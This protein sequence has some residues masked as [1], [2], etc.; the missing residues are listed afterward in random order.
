MVDNP[1]LF[2]PGIRIACAWGGGQN[3]YTTSCAVVSA[4]TD[5]ALS[6]ELSS[7][8]GIVVSPWTSGSVGGVQISMSSGTTPFS[9]TIILNAAT[10]GGSDFGPGSDIFEIPVV[11]MP[12]DFYSVNAVVYNYMD[13]PIN[14]I[15]LLNSSGF[16]GLDDVGYA[17]RPGVYKTNINTAAVVKTRQFEVGDLIVICENPVVYDYRQYRFAHVKTL[18]SAIVGSLCINR[19]FS[20]SSESAGELIWRMSPKESS[21]YNYIV[22]STYDDGWRFC[23]EIYGSTYVIDK[24]HTEYFGTATLIAPPHNR[25]DSGAVP[26]GDQAAYVPGLGIFST[27]GY[28]I[29]SSGETTTIYDRE[30]VYTPQWSGWN[31]QSEYKNTDRLLLYQN[32]DGYWVTASNFGEN[33]TL[34]STSVVINAPGAAFPFLPATSSGEIVADISGAGFTMSLPPE[35]G[36][37]IVNAGGIAGGGAEGW[38]PL[39]RCENIYNN[40]MN[41]SVYVV[42]SSFYDSSNCILDEFIND[43]KSVWHSSRSDDNMPPA[44]WE[45]NTV[46]SSTLSTYSSQCISSSSNIER[47]ISFSGGC[48]INVQNRDSTF[49]E[50]THIYGLDKMSG[51][52]VNVSK[53]PCKI[54]NIES[55]Y[56]LTSDYDHNWSDQNTAQGNIGGTQH[57]GS[58]QLNEI[59]NP[60]RCSLSITTRWSQHFIIFCCDACCGVQVGLV[61]ESLKQHRATPVYNRLQCQL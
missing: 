18:Q 10:T 30:C 9:T 17:F 34:V 20:P 21:A 4:T 22:S 25:W 56:L 12:N 38:Y 16:N 52:F 6:C 55:K 40:Y 46:N 7:D 29:N 49:G 1:V 28:Y 47:G 60:L 26:V 19:G 37:I 50:L 31:V 2:C 5:I 43:G 35:Q 61:P 58:T 48:L 53:I 23:C 33:E 11:G 57:S 8:G 13:G 51:S 15:T 44:I 59:Y 54:T 42:T 14:N 27:V 3:A 45:G 39:R 24:T 41:A 32:N 36:G